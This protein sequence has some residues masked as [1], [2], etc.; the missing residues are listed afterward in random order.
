MVP[1]N[2]IVHVW[3]LRYPLD[4]VPGTELVFG[5]LALYKTN[6]GWFAV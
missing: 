5:S 6:L 1:A 2:D 4:S 3:P